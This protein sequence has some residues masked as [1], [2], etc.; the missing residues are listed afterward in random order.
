LIIFNLISHAQVEFEF[1]ASPE[2][3]ANSLQRPL[4]TASAVSASAPVSPAVVA[5][6]NGSR[7]SKRCFKSR[8]HATDGSS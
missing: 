7:C 2:M 5:Q 6:A 4:M 3:A 1:S 8:V